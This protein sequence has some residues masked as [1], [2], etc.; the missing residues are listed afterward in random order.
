MINGL[1]KVLIVED[2]IFS[3]ENL[4]LFFSLHKS[5][6]EF[7]S[8]Y[9]DAVKI[10]NSEN[11]KLDIA[12][13]DVKLPTKSGID[14]VKFIKKNDLCLPVILITGFSDENAI[15]EAIKLGVDDFI[16]KPYEESELKHSI[17]KIL[18]K[19]QLKEENRYYKERLKRENEILRSNVG[20][21]NG[22]FKIIGES[23][24]F[25]DALMK[26]E[27]IAQYDINTIIY[28]ETGAGK[29][30]FAR[31][32]HENGKR[33]DGPLIAVNCSGIS[34]NL[35]ESE[36]FGFEKGTF[37]GAGEARAGLFETADKGILFMDEFT[38]I[39]I[40]FQSKLLRA[41]ETKSFFRVGGRNSI[42]VD[43][44][45]IA[46][47]NLTPHL[48]VREKKLREDLYHRIGEAEIMIPPLRNRKEDIL[49][50]VEHLIPIYAEEFNI[51]L[52]NLDKDLLKLI[53]EA[54]WSGNVRQLSNFLKKYCL[55]G[56]SVSREEVI[57]W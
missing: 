3:L 21:Q 2:D 28:G 35:F 22:R 54:D 53:K 8:N 40:E 36:F 55:F 43:I 16:K 32:I 34:S 9:Y 49:L 12:I 57:E 41:V 27:K 25:K 39:P 23:R 4:K 48:A 5:N 7:A 14:I 6:F 20:S 44:Q 50:L 1:S 30:I 10:I 24:V 26:A 11:G 45:I 38:E 29:E 19:K 51:P 17:E 56:A 13:I 18:E 42:K 46:A 33:K 47:T 52:P 37:T 31:Y 15:I